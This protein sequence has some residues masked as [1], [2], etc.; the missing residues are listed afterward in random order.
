MRPGTT[1]RGSSLCPRS[2]CT[3]HC[4][5]AAACTSIRITTNIV[6]MTACTVGRG[7]TSGKRMCMAWHLAGS[8]CDGR[9]S[10]CFLHRIKV[11]IRCVNSYRH[12]AA[13]PRHPS[14]S[15]ISSGIGRSDTHIDAAYRINRF[16]KLLD[17]FFQEHPI[18]FTSQFSATSKV[19]SLS[20]TFPIAT[21][22][23]PFLKSMTTA[24]VETISCTEMVLKAS[25]SM[26]RTS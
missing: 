9:C 14:A 20:D 12:P 2:S 8:Q 16:C 4:V 25:S 7:R 19:L 1:G 11:A 24:A 22:L 3:M 13:A 17:I 5:S 15:K 18:D 26:Y 21:P 10:A 6:R 23:P